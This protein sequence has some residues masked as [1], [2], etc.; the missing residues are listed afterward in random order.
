MLFFKNELDRA[1]TLLLQTSTFGD[2]LVS[3]FKNGLSLLKHYLSTNHLSTTTRTIANLCD[4]LGLSQASTLTPFVA[5]GLKS[6][7][8]S[9]FGHAV[10]VLTGSY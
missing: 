2:S 10:D 3:S 1:Q 4:A 8:E 5:L 9:T 6:G 7:Y